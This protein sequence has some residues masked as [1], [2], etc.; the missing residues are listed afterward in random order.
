MF[1][2]QGICPHDAGRVKWT[3]SLFTF[4]PITFFA[5][6]WIGAKRNLINQQQQ[7]DRELGMRFRTRWV[8]K[9]NRNK[10]KASGQWDSWNFA[11]WI[12]FHSNGGVFTTISCSFSSA[13]L[14]SSQRSG[15]KSA[16]ADLHRRCWNSTESYRWFDLIILLSRHML[17]YK[18]RACSL[19]VCEPSRTLHGAAG[20]SGLW[21][22]LLW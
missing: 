12:S 14:Y 5:S 13:Y 21:K 16:N 20:S 22:I 6:C 3:L 4:C 19:V 1:K 7:L 8:E 18:I 9:E 2:P 15:W 10:F 17:A 11:R